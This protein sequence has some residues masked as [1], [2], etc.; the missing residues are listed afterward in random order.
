M[1]CPLIAVQIYLSSQNYAPDAATLLAPPRC[2]SK[3]YLCRLAV[4]V[5]VASY[6][7]SPLLSTLWLWIPVG[8]A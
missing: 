7:S 5:F 3:A 1:S 4:A 6:N 2:A 8:P